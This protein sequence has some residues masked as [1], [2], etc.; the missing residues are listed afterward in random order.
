MMKV[1]FYEQVEDR[2][3]RFAVIMAMYQGQWIVVRHAQRLTWEIPGGHREADE[4]IDQTAARELQE[5]T[6]ALRFQLEPLCVYSVEG[7]TRV[8]ATGNESFGMLYYAKVDQ[9]DPVL[10]N[11]IQEIQTVSLLP[12]NLT[13]PDIQPHLFEEGIRL[14][15]ERRVQEW[16]AAWFDV[17]WDRFEV[18]FAKNVHYYESWGPYYVGLDKLRYWFKDWHTHAQLQEWRILGWTHARARTVVE[19]V[20]QCQDEKGETRFKGVSLI[21]WNT[22]NQIIELKE[23]ASTLPNVDPYPELDEKKP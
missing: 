3:I 12:P 22:A 9:L 23:Y 14:L 16:F 17:H 18:I 21:D 11:E 6:G 10:K 13:Y 15:R 20:F 5:E 1:R 19:W 8:N 4:T 7:K 2:Q